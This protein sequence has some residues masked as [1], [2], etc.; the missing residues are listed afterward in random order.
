MD[1]KIATS[2]EIAIWVLHDA[3][4]IVQRDPT[5]AKRFEKAYG[6]RVTIV[7]KAPPDPCIVA[8]HNDFDGFYKAFSYYG[9]TQLRQI[10]K[11]Y[12]L[13]TP[14]ELEI[15][16]KGRGNK[17]DDYINILWKASTIQCEALRIKHSLP[18]FPD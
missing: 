1:E 7:E 13:I 15:I 16:K 3:I 12:H 5:Y 6:K 10:A 4:S 18:T 9:A 17:V 8:L 2:K 11:K 14:D